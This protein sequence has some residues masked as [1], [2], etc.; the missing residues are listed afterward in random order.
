M[1]RN[2]LRLLGVVASV[3]MIGTALAGCGTQTA[4]PS[5]SGSDTAT[6]STQPVYGGTLQMDLSSQFPHLDPAK[7][8]DTTSYE[9]VL[10]FFNQLVTYQGATNNIVPDLATYT[11]SDGGKVYTFNIK[12]AKFWNGDPVTAQSF[13]TEFERV[14][15]NNMQSGGQGFIDPIIKGSAAY[16]A[17]KA[18]SVSGLQA[19]NS[20][21]LQ[22]TLQH[23]SA[24][25]L[26]VMAMPFFSAVDPS[27]IA[28]HPESYIDLHPMGT[29][30]FELA[31]YTPGK[32]YVLTKNPNY[33]VK[34]IPYLNKIVFN[35]NNSPS[36]VLFHFEQ[37]QTGLISWNQGGIPSED[38]LPLS[39]NPTYSGDIVK[40][41]EVSINYLG[42]NCVSGPT[43]HVAVRRAL[44]DAVNKQ[45]LVRILD[46]LALPANQI[47][48]PSMPSGYEPTLPAQ[49]QYT[50]NPTLAKQLLAKAGYPNGFNTTIYTDNSNPSDLK[51]A[52]AIQQ[53]FSQIGVH[54]QVNQT[55][56]NT[57]LTNN[58]TGKQN[59]FTL[60]W[61]EDFPDPS[62]FLNTLFNTN[63]IPVNDSTDY[64]NQQ[65]DA[66][67]NQG[68]LMPAGTARDNVYKQA[69]N[70][71]MSQAPWIPLVYPVYDAAVQPWVKGFYINP[72][73]VDPLQYMW[74]V[75]HNS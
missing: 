32:D 60:A 55:S 23:P 46:G 18:N 38:Y 21:T 14:L 75:P 13:I 74:V 43:K 65:V 33:F 56:W 10:Q 50:Y 45:V 6:N 69:Q 47:I 64:S 27:Y 29:G 9:A 19:L 26:Y 25:F 52:E 8:Y 61:I 72:N 22:I 71:I 48:P 63:Q 17:G 44:E 12:Q 67:L 73:L 3:A 30:P 31:S 34:G 11:I 66:L 35:I 57:F 36:A 40:K 39:N 16:V 4:T 20:N 62:D 24:T 58:E 59:M 1:K 49:D 70:I 5:Q 28:A 42:L 7:A 53:M 41:T 68:A 54:A 37:G 2:K 51:T 15:N